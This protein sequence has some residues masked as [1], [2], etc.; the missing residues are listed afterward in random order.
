MVQNKDVQS[1]ISRTRLLTILRLQEGINTSKGRKYLW[2][3]FIKRV[4]KKQASEEGSM[5]WEFYLG[6]IW[7][8]Q[9]CFGDWQL[10]HPE[11]KVKNTHTQMTDTSAMITN[12]PCDNVASKAIFSLQEEA[13][14]MTALGYLVSLKDLLF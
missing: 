8:V 14:L 10:E 5:F 3:G 1:P 4:L 9:L 7:Q 11:P 12:Q 13:A 6:T 2:E